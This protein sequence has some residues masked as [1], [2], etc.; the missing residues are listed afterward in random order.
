MSQRFAL[1]FAALILACFACGVAAGQGRGQLPIDE[2]DIEC[3]GGT[4]SQPNVSCGGTSS[5]TDYCYDGFG[6]CCGADYY[7]ANVQYNSPSCC[8]EQACFPGFVWASCRCERASPMIIDTTGKG[9]HLTS[10]EN[11]VLFDIEGNGK[12]IRIAWILQP[13]GTRSWP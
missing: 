3:C 1:V 10:A 9:F 7:T 6:S 8:A 11:G 12:P 4:Y 5:A 13:Q 2:G